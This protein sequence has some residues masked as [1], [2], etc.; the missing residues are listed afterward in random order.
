MGYSRLMTTPTCQ[1]KFLKEFSIV[2]DNTWHISATHQAHEI[3]HL[4]PKKQ[5]PGNSVFA[6][7]KYVEGIELLPKE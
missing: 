4:P 1:I 5:N 3:Y 6:V 7:L 2:S